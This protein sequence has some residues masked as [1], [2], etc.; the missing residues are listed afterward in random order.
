LPRPRGHPEED[1]R[2]A[3]GLGLGG[4]DWY[5]SEEFDTPIFTLFLLKLL[6]LAA[7]FALL[8]AHLVA[9]ATRV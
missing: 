5:A 1:R 7:G 6:T 8:A 2:Q 4:D 9:S 3:A